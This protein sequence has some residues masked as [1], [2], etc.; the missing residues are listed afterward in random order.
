MS[1]GVNTCA[2]G[3]GRS[4]QWRCRGRVWCWTAKWPPERW[5][6]RSRTGQEWTSQWSDLHHQFVSHLREQWVGQSSEVLK[7]KLHWHDGVHR[8]TCN[9]SINIYLNILLETR[10]NQKNRNIIWKS[11]NAP[12]QSCQQCEEKKN[13]Q[14]PAPPKKMS[15]ELDIYIYLFS[16]QLCTERKMLM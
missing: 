12:S 14:T 3:E 11:G 13:T 8:V 5:T 1:A 6:E 4:S 9:M 15:P 2:S 10:S 16:L 7:C